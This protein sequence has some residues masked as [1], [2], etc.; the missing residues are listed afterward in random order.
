MTLQ[1]QWNEW[2]AIRKHQRRLRNMLRAGVITSLWYYDCAVLDRQRAYA[3]R[4]NWLVR[5]FT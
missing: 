1:Q 3:S 2:R 4:T 5:W